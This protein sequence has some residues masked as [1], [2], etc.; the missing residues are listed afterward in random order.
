MK[1]VTVLDPNMPRETDREFL[2]ESIDELLEHF[3]QRKTYSN[4]HMLVTTHSEFAGFVKAHPFSDGYPTF[5]PVLYSQIRIIDECDNKVEG[6]DELRSRLSRIMR[7]NPPDAKPKIAPV[8]TRF[9]ELMDETTKNVDLLESLTGD[10]SEEDEP[11]MNLRILIGEAFKTMTSLARGK[12]M[13]IKLNILRKQYK[14]I[15]MG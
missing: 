9:Y 6:E 10:F 12:A 7:D 14:N 15:R 11:I 13:E 2:Y 4:I 8:N 1:I 3:P 5:R